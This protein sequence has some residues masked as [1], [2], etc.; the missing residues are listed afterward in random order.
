[1]IKYIQ[2]QLRSA[3]GIG[4]G[5][6]ISFINMNEGDIVLLKSDRRLLM[7]EIRRVKK[8]L[9]DSGTKNKVIVLDAGLDIQIIQRDERV[10]LDLVTAG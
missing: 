2:K 4:K 7:S 6:S 10:E 9:E 8:D 5:G 3:L 1:M